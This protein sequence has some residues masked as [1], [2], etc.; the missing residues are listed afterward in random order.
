MF[1][2]FLIKP[3]QLY[4]ETQLIRIRGLLAESLA[5]K[6][7][8]IPSSAD[9]KKQVTDEKPSVT[10]KEV[11]SKKEV[12]NNLGIVDLKKAEKKTEA[13]MKRLADDNSIKEATTALEKQ[14][15]IDKAN[16]I[17][18]YLAHTLSKR[19]LLEEI[20]DS[21]IKIKKQQSVFSWFVLPR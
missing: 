17:K 19:I 21:K 7:K 10:L 16:D 6:D 14:K 5:K 4:P 15:Q 12:N 2:I 8:Q 3:N 18:S 20:A 1:Q 9:K 11:Q 13:L